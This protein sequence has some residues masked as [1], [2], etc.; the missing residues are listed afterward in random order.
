MAILNNIDLEK[1][2]RTISEAKSNKEALR[3]KTK[4]SGEWVLDS[5][6]DF[7]FITVLEYENGKQILEIDSPSWL[8]GKGKRPG[9]IQYCLA[10]LTSC[11]LATIAT[12]ASMKGI[13]LAKLKSDTE[14]SLN[15]SKTLDLGDEPIIEE[16]NFAIEIEADVDR[17]DLEELIKEA[18]EKCPAI[19]SL[20]NIIKANAYL[21]T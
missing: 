11:F 5:S 13:K 19:Y 1:I 6:K 9:P 12:I 21:K 17:K 18:L 8:G 2:N 7:Q 15:F 10:G 3:R 4:L 16:V 14:C 20:R